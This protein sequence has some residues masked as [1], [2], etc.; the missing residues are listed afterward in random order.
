MYRG[1]TGGGRAGPAYAPAGDD[2]F[3]EQVQ[4]ALEHLYDNVFLQA[5]PLAGLVD[6]GH[7]HGNR[8]AMVHR[9][10]IEAID[11]LKPPPAT[12]PHSH[13]WRRYR[14]AFMRYVEGATVA[15]IAEELAISERQA[16]RDNHEALASIVELL[17]ARFPRA[18]ATSGR[19]PA[20]S[21]EPAADLDQELARIGTREPHATTRVEDVARGVCETVARLAEGKGVAIELGARGDLPAT[22]VDRMAVRQI[23]LGQLLRAVDMAARGQRVRLDVW[24][25]GGLVDV[26]VSLDL[27]GGQLRVPGDAGDRLAIGKRLARA[28]GGSLE[29]AVEGGRLSLRLSLPAVRLA[30]VLLVDDNPG[31]LR[32]LRRYLGGSAYTVV[33]AQSA[34]AALAMARDL[35]PDVITLDVMMPESDGWETLQALRAHP[36]TRDIPVVV[37]SV[38]K[39]RELALSLGAA[40]FLAKPVTQEALLRALSEVVRPPTD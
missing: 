20:D 34:E 31:M 13:L 10:L 15:R 9:R 35:R 5:H 33:E 26:V 39:E 1:T 30:T 6:D 8:G 38:L 4:A 18:A 14:H 27:G 11:E 21:A 32:L 3:A 25:A 19:D 16:R 28:H 17:R 23:V 37:C 7:A 29:E 40:G 12:P 24:A 2:D 22:R 36:R